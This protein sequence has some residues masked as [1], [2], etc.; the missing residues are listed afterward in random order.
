MNTLL[1]EFPAVM[2]PCREYFPDIEFTSSDADK[3]PSD[4]ILSIATHFALQTLINIRRQLTRIFFL[5]ITD[6]TNA[7]EV[8]TEIPSSRVIEIF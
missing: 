3:S 1:L 6:K 8:L 2:S 7:N 5:L 4:T